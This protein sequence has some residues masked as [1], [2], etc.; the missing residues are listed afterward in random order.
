MRGL[1]SL[2]C[3]S[4][5]RR[6]VCVLCLFSDWLNTQAVP[7]DH[8]K[9]AHAVL[10]G[11]LPPAAALAVGGVALAAAGLVVLTVLNVIRQVVRHFSHY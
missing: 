11:H 4:R 7:M 6:F 10:R 8:V 9:L 3:R 1:S 5:S 2:L